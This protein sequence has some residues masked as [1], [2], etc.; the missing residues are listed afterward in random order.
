MASVTVRVKPR[1]VGWV[2]E[3]ATKVGVSVF[4]LMRLTVGPPVCAQLKL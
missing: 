3:G 2:T 4:A 1:V